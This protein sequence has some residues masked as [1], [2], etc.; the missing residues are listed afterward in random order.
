MANLER[1][2]IYRL[3]QA[4]ADAATLHE[5]AARVL[6]VENY[7]YH[8]DQE[9]LTV[10]SG[11]KVVEVYRGSG[12]IWAADEEQLWN[13]R[14]SGASAKSGVAVRRWSEEVPHGITASRAH[15]RRNGG[16]HPPGE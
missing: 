15:C 14:L 8:E 16:A 3:S 11:P 6:S 10:R 5:L 4:E 7:T 2:P 12:G 13:P 1:L 9:R